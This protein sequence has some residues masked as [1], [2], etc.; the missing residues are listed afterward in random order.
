[1][2]EKTHSKKTHEEYLHIVDMILYNL[3]YL[4]L[5]YSLEDLPKKSL[6]LLINVVSQSEMKYRLN[7]SSIW[8]ALLS[9]VKALHDQ[10][11]TF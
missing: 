6:V 1:M 11:K 2:F 9:K 8:T 4:V 7:Y 3:K 10:L 5:S